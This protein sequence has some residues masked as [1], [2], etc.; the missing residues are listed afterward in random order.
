[1]KA[2]ICAVGGWKKGERQQARPCVV[3]CNARYGL[4]YRRE[5]KMKA[6]PSICVVC[7]MLRGVCKAMRGEKRREATSK[8]QDLRGALRCEVRVGIQQRQQYEPSNCVVYCDARRV[9]IQERQK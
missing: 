6:Q 7:V 9:R 1:M 5:A 4:E 3:Y 8:A 2:M